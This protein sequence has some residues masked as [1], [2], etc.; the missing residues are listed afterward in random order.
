MLEFYELDMLKNL[1]YNKNNRGSILSN[2]PKSYDCD[3]GVLLTSLQ[4]KG[5]I[6][7]NFIVTDLGMEA[8]KP[9]KV[10]NAIIMAAGMSTRFAPLSY[11]KPKALL[12]VKGELLI[13]REIEQL[14]E[15]GIKDIT[16]VVGYMKEKLFYLE[17]K[18]N[19]KIVV[20][21]DYFKYNNTSTLKLVEKDLRNTYICSSDNYFS[22]NPFEAYVYKAYYAAVYADGKTD[23]YCLSV[24]END[25]IVRVSIGGANSWYMLGHVYFDKKFSETFVSILEEE[26]SNQVTRDNLW[27]NLYIRYIDKL[28]MYIKRYNSD[29]IKE[30]DSLEELRC[31][32][33]DYISNSNSLIFKNISKILK[34]RDEEIVDIHPIKTGITNMSFSFCYNGIKYVYRHPGVGTEA[35]IN[36]CSEFESMKIAKELGLD[37]TFIYLDKVEGWKISYY[38][39]DARILDYHNQEHV[40]KAL[41]S[42]KKLHESGIKTDYKFDVWNNILDFKKKLDKVNRTDFED[43]CFLYEQVKTVYEYTKQDK[44][45]YT[46]CHCDSYGPNFIFDG[47][48]KVYLIDWEYSGMSDRAVDVGTFIACSDYSLEEAYNT[49]ELYLGYKPSDKELGHFVVYIA[50][51]SFYWFMWALYQESVGKPVCKYLYIWYK[52]SKRYAKRAIC[53]YEGR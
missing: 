50:L 48:E 14:L 10:D 27:E 13:E 33:R 22:K 38:I 4:E 16:V 36:R 26:Y 41:C 17:E 18:Y 5:F 30:F 12:R 51:A 46:M 29:E 20:N 2:I 34:C 8:M 24:D 39:E 28:D 19:V 3:I 40:K 1:I 35:Y 7:N 49:I 23:E 32:D 11:E 53:I 31:F 37:D 21:N 25:K 6:T 52:Y 44:V 15:A 47:Q 43:M 45:A 42:L 9:Y